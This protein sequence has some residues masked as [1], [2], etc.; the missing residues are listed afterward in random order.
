MTKATPAD[1]LTAMLQIRRFEEQC[2]ALAAAQQ[3]PGHYH[4]YIGQEATGVAAC[5]ALRPEDF[6]FS[7]WRNHGHLLARGA[8]PDKMLAE[9]LGRATGYAGGKSGTLHLS[10]RELGIPSTSALVGGS[11]PLATGAAL[12]CKRRGSGISV[13]FFG[14]AALEEGA[15]YEAVLLAQ[16]WQLPIL[17]ICENNAIPPA[18]RK[19]GQYTSSTLPAQRLVDVPE[20]LQIPAESIDGRD[21]DQMAATFARLA[22]EVRS[23]AGPRF[24]EVCVP[25]WPGNIMTWPELTGGNWQVAW[26]FG[27]TS[28]DEKMAT[29]LKSDPLLLYVKA[30]V[31]AGALDRAAVEAIDKRVTA[32]MKQAAQFAVDSPFPAAQEAYRHVFAQGAAA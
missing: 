10:V 2:I 20:A 18:E 22:G 1:R 11:L 15:F 19:R 5:E 28:D 4:V 13:A 17:F 24:I 30:Q 7:T 29:W 9:I 3:L 16:V 32:G 27:A 26:A 14:D 25:R 12:A 23:G 31:A 21:V 6:I 8:S